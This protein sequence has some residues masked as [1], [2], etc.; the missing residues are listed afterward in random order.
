MNII[1]VEIER[2]LFCLPNTPLI[3]IIDINKYLLEPQKLINQPPILL[4]NI[5]KR[6]IGGFIC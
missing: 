6:I 4:T 3:H 1:I 2:T 5:L